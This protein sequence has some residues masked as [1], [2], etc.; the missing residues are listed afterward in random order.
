MPD[1]GFRGVVS[2]DQGEG[3]A[4]DFEVWFAAQGADQGTG[5]NRLAATEGPAQQNDLAGAQQGREVRRKARCGRFGIGLN[6]NGKFHALHY[7]T[8]NRL[9]LWGRGVGKM[10]V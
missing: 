2:L 4:R 3:R 1:R 9:W 5:E 10:E 7:I 6:L 8:P